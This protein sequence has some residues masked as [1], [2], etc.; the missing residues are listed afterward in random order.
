[1]AGAI[2]ERSGIDGVPDHA[3]QLVSLIHHRERRTGD[4]N[5]IGV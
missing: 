4:T 3:I 2:L 1:M 5:G